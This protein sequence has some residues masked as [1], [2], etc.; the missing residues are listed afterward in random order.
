[1]I[2]YLLGVVT[3][4]LFSFIFIGGNNDKDKIIQDLRNELKEVIRE[5]E[6]LRKHR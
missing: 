2:K 1:M 5:N 4:S 3:G 6:A